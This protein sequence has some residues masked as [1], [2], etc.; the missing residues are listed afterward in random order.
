MKNNAIEKVENI[1]KEKKKDKKEPEKKDKKKQIKNHSQKNN[2]T[3]KIQDKPLTIIVV[4]SV[5]LV[6]MCSAFLFSVIM[7]SER[8]SEYETSVK[9]SFFSTVSEV[10]NIDSNLSK[11]IVSN[12]NAK[13]L[14]YLST[15]AINGELANSDL[16]SLPLTDD[17]KYYV[18]K[19][20][21]QIADY[22]KYLHK[23]IAEGED[24]TEEDKKG[25]H[26]IYEINAV[27][28]NAFDKMQENMSGDYTFSSMLSGGNG[29]VVINGFSE[30]TN[31]SQDFPELIYD[32]PFSDG[33]KD[34]VIKGLK[35]N[36][37]S[38]EQALQTV[39]DVFNDYGL[40]DIRYNGEVKSDVEGYNFEGE[41][42]GEKLFATV[43]K[44]EGK[45]LSFSV[46]GN[47]KSVKY[48]NDEAV[49]RAIGFL[50]KIGIKDVTAVWINLSS[51]NV[52]TIN[53]TTQIDEV[54]CYADLIKVRVCAYTGMV[55]GADLT[56][57]Y[58]NHTERSVDVPVIDETTARDCVSKNISIKNV[59][60]CVVPLE[61]TNT[62]RLCYEIMGE[63]D[64]T[65]YY[66][67]IDAENKRE[68]K[69]FKVINSTEGEL[70][71]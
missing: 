50:E 9:R 39:K 69:I 37:V 22:S 30:L 70:L 64:D 36:D 15:T 43:T 67:Y 71:M 29:N 6:I 66:V 11:A 21:N 1:I 16:V 12:D 63:Y 53:I 10:N 3:G 58:T 47:C 57:Y 65:T 27:L 41:I 28:K 62:E 52:Y 46:A 48:Q 49:S 2:S 51:S 35:G 33:K 20:I 38:A 26:D 40:T 7:P 44:K 56:S 32:G 17:V 42:K 8:E 14:S 59:R 23:K 5:A 13:L 24:L 31:M 60:L 55:I 4:L 18:I 19:A 34:T 45:L 61:N 54:I 25:L 68:I